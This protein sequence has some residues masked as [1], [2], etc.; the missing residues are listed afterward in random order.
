[1]CAIMTGYIKCGEAHRADSA[2]AGGTGHGLCD[3]NE[4]IMAL[5]VQ[6]AYPSILS[7]QLKYLSL[8]MCFFKL[9]NLIIYEDNIYGIPTTCQAVFQVLIAQ[10]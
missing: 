10:P 9:S 3:R 7:S 6:S 2:K 8:K 4:E 5:F 1:M